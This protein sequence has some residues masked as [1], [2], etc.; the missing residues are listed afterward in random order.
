MKKGFDLQLFRLEKGRV[1]G[2]TQ[3]TARIGCD[4]DEVVRFALDTPDMPW[5]EAKYLICDIEGEQDWSQVFVF[6][7]WDQDGA[8]DDIYPDITIRMS[9]IPQ[10]KTRL[11]LP[12]RA[13]NAQN[14]FL[15]RTRGQLRSFI[16]GV[17]VPLDRI[18]KFAFA[19]REG[20][21]TQ[22]VRILDA[23]LT[24][25][26]PDFP[27]PQVKL[28]DELGQNKACS[29][30]GKTLSAQDM[31]N[32]LRSE[33]ESAKE[34]DWAKGLSQYGGLKARHYE[35]SG[36]FRVV[37]DD[38]RWWLVDPDGC[39]YFGAG[40]DCVRP[41]EEGP[42]NSI[43][44]LFDWLPPVDGEFASAWHNVERWAKWE[45]FLQEDL[46]QFCY[47][48]AN[49]IR[50]FG[51]NW[52]DAW[53]TI[54]K[55]RMKQWMFNTVGVGSDAR[56]LSESKI[57]Y[58]TTL[59]GYPT[60]V[61]QVYR[62]FPD[63]Y[64]EEFRASAAEY[65]AQLSAFAGDRT[66]IGY[67]MR[68]EPQWAFAYDLE[69]AEEL[70]AAPGE[71]A[72]KDKFIQILQAKYD[73]IDEL[74]TA[75]KLCLKSFDELKQP[76]DHAARLSPAA[77]KDLDDF[78][79]HMIR[80]YVKVPAEACRKVDPD[81][82]NLGMR[83][84]FILYP[85]QAAGKEFL[86]VFSINSY[87]IDPTAIL[88]EIADVVKMP[89]MIGEFHFGAL[90]VGVRATGIIGVENQQERG[91]AYQYYLEK[92]AAVP[93]CVA[94]QYFILNDQ[95]TLGRPDG[96]NYQIGFVDCCHYPYQ[97]MVEGAIRAHTRM[98]DVHAGVLPPT[99]VIPKKITPNM[100]S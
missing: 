51:E 36:Y 95:M 63:V 69:I 22:D 28:V 23:Y 14:I 13:L 97:P 41:G 88:T 67:F 98:Y 94:V 37:Q 56:F 81:H 2:V 52:H 4:K 84:A 11:C 9:A 92:S 87:K 42:V 31:V 83:Y 38:G 86:D 93:E 27:L 33:Y 40:M 90:D 46:W 65:S 21:A 16:T 85:N 44:P 76:I 68:N 32:F 79:Y 96:E 12:L 58:V 49:L 29:W 45:G 64:S 54:T 7:F 50:A 48:E 60:T 24:D 91:K 19:L 61:K 70:L 6:E 30:E 20:P 80:E 34:A 73:T 74:N 1:D 99:D 53:L 15:P 47:A 26:L 39:A 66:L 78:S 75:W 43:A 72:S 5:S 82:L 57:P 77:K 71:Y 55:S 18:E 17:A 59:I 3:K 10:F 62:D 100:A 8:H 89:V 25:E 35:A